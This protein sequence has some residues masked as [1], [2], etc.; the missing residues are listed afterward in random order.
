MAYKNIGVLDRA[1]EHLQYHRPIEYDQYPK[2]SS[3][4]VGL[5]HLVHSTFSRTLTRLWPQLPGMLCCWGQPIMAS[6][7]S[8][9]TFGSLAA[10]TIARRGDLNTNA[11]T[12]MCEICP[13]QGRFQGH[14]SYQWEG[15]VDGVCILP[16][17]AN[18]LLHRTP[19][20]RDFTIRKHTFSMSQRML[21]VRCPAHLRLWT[22]VLPLVVP[23]RDHASMI[24]RVALRF[25]HSPRLSPLC[26][27]RTLVSQ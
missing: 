19:S 12:A 11:L 16:T 1:P 13:H 9:R 21:I 23:M 25:D 24:Y 2:I 7:F 8:T 14:K 20:T 3:H 18:R 26:F 27:V 17:Y 5:Y 15:L 22:A 6:K 4:A 10:N